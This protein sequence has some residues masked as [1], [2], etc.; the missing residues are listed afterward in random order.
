MRVTDAQ[1]SDADMLER[2]REL[3][4]D[5]LPPGWAVRSSSQAP[6]S[7][8]VDMIVELV[9]PDGAM[10]HLLFE[11]KRNVDGRDVASIAHQL[12]RFTSALP[13]ST[14]VLVAR[15]LSPPVRDRLADEGLSYVD[16]T[17]NV[18]VTLSR[19]GLFVSDHGADR[20]PWRGRGRPRGDLKGAPAA[21]VVRALLDFDREWSIR[22]LVAAAQVSTGAAYRVVE[23]LDE[24]G[25][26]QRPRARVLV[27]DWQRL[28]RRWSQDYEFVESSRTTR[29]IAS[30]GLDRL[31]ARAAED[32]VQYAVTGT[33]AAAEWAPYAPARA[34][35]IYTPD[36]RGAAEAW[37]LRPAEAGA[38]V[39]LAEPESDVVF[40][41]SRRAADGGYQI[42]A[43]TQVAV[44]LM[45]G[46]GR[47]P[48]E[49]EE[50]IDWMARNE[51]SWRP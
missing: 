17:G 6:A 43:P 23:F 11:V 5:R 14:G 22:Q 12:E 41:R 51:P 39:V 37:D 27:P 40:A 32:R 16:A 33:L 21:K 4:A 26:V 50:L 3:L 48:A 36:A 31:L 9:S 10:S 20:D 30:R 49:A 38:N 42:T 34:A 35:M 29:W 45:T 18:R 28:L 13:G 25:L 19:P 2:G 46:P 1:P 24:E 7:A 15:Y 8:G 44:D 47:N